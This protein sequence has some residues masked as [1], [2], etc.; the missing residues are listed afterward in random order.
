M[1]GNEDIL[2]ER[3]E[4]NLEPSKVETENGPIYMDEEARSTVCIRWSLLKNSAI[5]EDIEWRKENKR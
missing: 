4:D 2:R 5:R 3:D 1:R